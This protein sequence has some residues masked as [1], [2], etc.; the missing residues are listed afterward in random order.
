MTTLQLYNADCLEQ[1]KSIPDKSIDLIICDLPYGCLIRGDDKF[2]QDRKKQNPNG[3]LGGC[4]WDIKIDLDLFWKQI[5]RI[6]KNDHT[7]CIH[8][9]STRFGID[10]INSNEKEF[11]YD[12]VWCKS[13]AVGFL[14]ANKKPMAAHEM[15]YVF[16]KKGS[17]YNRID[18]KGDFPALSGGSGT[19]LTHFKAKR[20]GKTLAGS[21][22]V[23][24]LVEI[25]NSNHKS[26]HPTAKPVDLYK[27]LI[28]RY[29]NEGDTVL[30]P[31]FGSC[32]SGQVCKDLKRNYIGIEM[33]KEFFDKAMITVGGLT[34]V[35]PVIL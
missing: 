19:D 24:S 21:R 15:I 25:S 31:T 9:C 20:T 30:D 12:L 17:N 32:N 4:A 8:F 3:S 27:W 1:M 16:S 14:S 10:L 29:S 22:C 2:R 34:G 35:T 33:N 13:T 28:E 7:P 5:K 23:K 18:V 26:N 11:R 6:R